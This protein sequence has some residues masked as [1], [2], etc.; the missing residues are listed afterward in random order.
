MTNV[1][2]NLAWAPVTVIKKTLE[3]TTQMFHNMYRMPLRKHF[4]SRFSAANVPKCNKALA[5]DTIYASVPAHKN[6]VKMALISV[7]KCTT[8]TAIYPWISQNDIPYKLEDN[9]R[10]RGAMNCLISDDAK[11]NLSNQIKDLLRLYCIGNYQ[12]SVFPK[13]LGRIVGITCKMGDTLTYQILDED[14]QE[15]SFRSSICPKILCET[16][17]QPQV[18]GEENHLLPS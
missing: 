13:K 2:P 15:I 12:P 14:S 7:G 11:S 5:T 18:T 16:R 17:G 6:G 4:K 10:E 3:N 8:I 1:S 9:I